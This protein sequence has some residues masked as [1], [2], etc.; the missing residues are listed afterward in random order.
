MT[1]LVLALFLQNADAGELAGVTAPDTAT[2][3]G[4]TLVLNGMGLREK[5]FFDIYVGSLYLP[6][7]TTSGASVISQDVPKRIEMTFIYSAVTTAQL[8][9]TYDE[10]LQYM[11]D[12]SAVK[13]RFET[14]KSYMSDVVAGDKITYDYVPGTGTIVNVKGVVKGT[15][16]GKDFSDALF[17]V[18][19]GAHPPTGNLKKGLLGG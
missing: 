14:L 9:E 15:I 4:Q 6:A 16:P 19:V 8:C 10:D 1:A 12:P 5:Y 11:P 17:T 13:D 3:G 7:K 18:Y 2:V